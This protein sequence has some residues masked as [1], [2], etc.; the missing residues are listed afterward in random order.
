MDVIVP[1][2]SLIKVSVNQKVKG[3]LTVIA[4]VNTA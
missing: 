2:E 4:E 3:G 1:E